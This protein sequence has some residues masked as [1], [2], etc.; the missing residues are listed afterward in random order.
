VVDKKKLQDGRSCFDC[1]VT[2]VEFHKHHV[3]PKSKGGVGTVDLC[4]DCHSVVHERR[5][6]SSQLIKDAIAKVRAQGGTWGGDA[7]HMASMRER[8]NE[9]RHAKHLEYLLGLM[10]ATAFINL[11][12]TSTDRLTQQRTAEKLNEM[13]FKTP[14]GTKMSPG[15]YRQ[16]LMKVREYEEEIQQLIESKHPEEETQWLN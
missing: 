13:N 3:V 7:E 2:G 5:F 11:L 14:R 15:Y 8:S 1:G 6:S 9:I 10:Q 16:C 4:L 12:H